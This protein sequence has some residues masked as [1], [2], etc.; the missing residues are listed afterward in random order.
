MY[1]F[2]DRRFQD[3]KEYADELERMFKSLL[4]TRAVSV[5]LFNGLMAFFFSVCVCR[6]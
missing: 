6:K 1:L 2:H 5:K 3:A 4:E